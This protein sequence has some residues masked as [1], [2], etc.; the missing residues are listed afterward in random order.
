ML[1]WMWIIEDKVIQEGFPR[2]FHEVFRGLPRHVKII[3]AIY[4]KQ[5]GNIVVFKGEHT[6]SL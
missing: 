1:Q 2:P 3:K 4:E 5:N 6:F